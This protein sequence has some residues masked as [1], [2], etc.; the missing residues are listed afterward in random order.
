[1]PLSAHAKLAY[2]AYS[3]GVLQVALAKHSF[4][5]LEKIR[6]EEYVILSNRVAFVFLFFVFDKSGGLPKFMYFNIYILSS[7]DTHWLFAAL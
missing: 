5:C 6:M 3:F 7:V 1:M 4:V 2:L